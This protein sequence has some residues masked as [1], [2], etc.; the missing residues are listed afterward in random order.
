[1]G[2]SVKVPRLPKCDLCSA[3]AAYNAKSK[4]GPWGYMCEEH[5]AEH[6]IGLGTGRGQRLILTEPDNAS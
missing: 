3:T 2:E 1:M 4:R 6:G 5:Y